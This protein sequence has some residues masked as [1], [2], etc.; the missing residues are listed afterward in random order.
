MKIM[1]DIIIRFIDHV[2]L[3]M[4]HVFIG[5]NFGALLFVLSLVFHVSVSLL[6]H[7]DEFQIML[8]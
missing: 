2:T 1:H 3:Y 6:L 4:H 5:Q 8:I 7:F